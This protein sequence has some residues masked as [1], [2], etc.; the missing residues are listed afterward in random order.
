[1]RLQTRHLGSGTGFTWIGM[2][3]I[4]S[5]GRDNM[6]R[7]LHVMRAAF[8]A[9]VACLAGVASTACD[10]GPKDTQAVF[11]TLLFESALDPQTVGGAVKDYTGDNVPDLF[12][13]VRP[14]SGQS[15]AAILT[16]DPGGEY[17][18]LVKTLKTGEVA[19][20]DA[21]KSGIEVGRGEINHLLE[22]MEGLRTVV[23]GMPVSRQ[24]EWGV[25]TGI[26]QATINDCWATSYGG[27]GVLCG[28]ERGREQVCFGCCVDES[29]LEHDRGGWMWWVPNC[30]G[31]RNLGNWG[32]NDQTS[33]T[34][35]LTSNTVR[36][37][38]N[39]VGCS[40]GAWMD[41]PPGY[42]TCWADGAHWWNDKLTAVYSHCG[43]GCWDTGGDDCHI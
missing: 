38:E 37:S 13:V 21:A 16:G 4:A 25:D 7:H 6:R 27:H 43:T 20:P 31:I 5:K 28:W 8:L 29:P 19:T 23:D 2:R 26:I 10:T 40:A 30:R 3:P 34:K 14:E 11:G 32:M 36:L 12:M 42:Y 33:A 17:R 35:N 24:R 41:E 39:C 18:L 1:M 9:C 22:R 15:V